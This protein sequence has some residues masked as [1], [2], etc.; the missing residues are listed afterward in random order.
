MRQPWHADDAGAGRCFQKIRL[1]FEKL[2]ELGSPTRVCFPAPLKSSLIAQDQNEEKAEAHF[3]D[4]SF[5]VMAGIHCLGGIIGNEAKQRKW[6]KKK[7]RT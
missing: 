5:K 7:A 2:K 4:F 6:V 3:L 1:C